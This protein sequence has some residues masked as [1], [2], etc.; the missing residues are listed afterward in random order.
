M[1]GIDMPTYEAISGNF[2]QSKRRTAM[3]SREPRLLLGITSR[4]YPTH[5]PCPLSI[6]TSR[7]Y[8][9]FAR[10]PSSLIFCVVLARFFMSRT[11]RL[12]GCKKDASR[13]PFPSSLDVRRYVGMK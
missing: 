7:H 12:P 10:L 4:R 11:P 2:L 5:L 3:Q 6:E 13:K 1:H 9:T 8:A